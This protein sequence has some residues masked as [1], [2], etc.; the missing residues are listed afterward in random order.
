MQFQQL[1]NEYGKNSN[2]LNIQVSY[3]EFLAF[4]K[5]DPEKAIS[6]LKNTLKLPLNEFQNGYVKTKLADILVFTNQFNT[7][8]IY[9]T[10]V[11]NSLKN[12]EIGQNARFKIA[13]TSYFKGDFDWSQSQLQILKNSTSQFISNDALA[14]NLLIADN[15]VKDSLERL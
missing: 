6:E 11:Q 12:H 4:K 8:L 7:A 9:Y 13:Q 2:T 15:V 3:A 1:F 5:N 10:Q 14:L